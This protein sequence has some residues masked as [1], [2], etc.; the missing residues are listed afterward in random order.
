MEYS[1][2][3]HHSIF[4]QSIAAVAAPTGQCAQHCSAR[5]TNETTPLLHP[6]RVYPD[7]TIPTSNPVALD[8]GS[9]GCRTRDPV[10]GDPAITHSSPT[11]MSIAPDIAAPRCHGLCFNPNRRRCLRYDNFAIPGSRRNFSIP[12]SSR[13]NFASHRRRTR[14]WHRFADYATA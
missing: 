12:W 1:A 11:P 4:T 9:S 10:A 5:P 3:L 13:R 2:L 14:H 6:P 7:P 8:V